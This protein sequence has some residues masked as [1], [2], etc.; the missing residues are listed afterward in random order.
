MIPP[1][2][3]TTT[4]ITFALVGQNKLDK[5]IIDIQC[6][7]GAIFI[8]NVF[9]NCQTPYSF[10]ILDNSVSAFSSKYLNKSLTT[11]KLSVNHM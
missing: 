8:N 5:R 9:K 2:G 4:P 6:K 7:I 3:N 11:A 1:C 10:L